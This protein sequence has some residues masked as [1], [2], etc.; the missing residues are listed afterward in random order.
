MLTGCKDFWDTTADLLRIN[1]KDAEAQDKTETRIKTYVINPE[2]FEVLLDTE[3][4]PTPTYQIID[5]ATELT[6]RSEGLLV[7]GTGDSTV[8]LE[9]G[10][11]LILRLDGSTGSVTLIRND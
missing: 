9:L 4:D 1:D 5:S 6:I 11:I 10:D 2:G 8:A 7:R 3:G